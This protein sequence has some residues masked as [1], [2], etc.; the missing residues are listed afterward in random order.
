MSNKN[1]TPGPWSGRGQEVTGPHGASICYCVANSRAG[2]GFNVQIKQAEAKSNAHLIRAAPELYE[3]AHDLREAQKAYLLD[4]GNDALGKA[5]AN[6][7]KKLDAAL[8]KARGEHTAS[9]A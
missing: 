2:S 6:A 3:A 9:G 1:W 7:A 8:A 4:R 5:V